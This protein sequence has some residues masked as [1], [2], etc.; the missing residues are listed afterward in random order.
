MTWAPASSSSTATLGGGS[1]SSCSGAR[2]WPRSG[3]PS[4]RAGEGP[5][6]KSA[7]IPLSRS[8]CPG[9]S[10]RRWLPYGPATL[11]GS[12]RRCILVYSLPQNLWQSTASLQPSTLL[13]PVLRRAFLG[14]PHP[15]STKFSSNAFASPLAAMTTLPDGRRRPP[16]GG[17]LQLVRSSGQLHRGWQRHRGKVEGDR[18][19]QEEIL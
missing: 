16:D 1:L 9:A 8:T 12:Q 6:P 4:S 18:R 2:P 11:V 7:S 14:S 3:T 19:K 5:E 13:R 15:T 10:P 17:H